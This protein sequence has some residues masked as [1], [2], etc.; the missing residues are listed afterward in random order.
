M[1]DFS[2]PLAGL[3]CIYMYQGKWRRTWS[4]LRGGALE[5]TGLGVGWLGGRGG[6]GGYENFSR[7]NFF[8]HEPNVCRIFFLRPK[9]CTNFFFQI[10]LL[11]QLI[12]RLTWHFKSVTYSFIHFEDIFGSKD[13]MTNKCSFHV[14]CKKFSFRKFNQTYKIA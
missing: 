8:F 10:C 7:T 4:R 6:G 14:Q 13:L 12:E 11:L 1:R 2:I 5:I 3:K 9:L